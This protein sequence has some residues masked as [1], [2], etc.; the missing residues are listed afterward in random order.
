MLALLLALAA[1]V[2]W[3]VSALTGAHMSRGMNPFRA[4]A[5]NMGLG[6]LMLLP[7]VAVSLS[8]LPQGS[9]WLWLLATGVA[10]VLA[11]LCDYE[12]VRYGPVGLIGAIASTE[13]A[14][15]A[16]LAIAFGERPSPLLLIAIPVLTAGLLMVMLPSELTHVHASNWPRA[17]TFASLAALFFGIGVYAAGQ[18]ASQLPVVWAIVP[19]RAIGTVALVIPLAATARMA[20][21]KALLPWALVTSVCDLLGFAFFG[22]AARGSIVIAAIVSGQFGVLAVIFAA[23]RL[24]EHLTRRQALGVAFVGLGIAMVAG[25]SAL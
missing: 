24:H 8:Q 9:E 16:L 21:P 1:A 14:V 13:G 19:A 15:A 18:I 23:V 6:M 3:G 7:F 5:W 22:L 17:V 11:F 2:S 10:T 20:L 12:G 25:A 4:L